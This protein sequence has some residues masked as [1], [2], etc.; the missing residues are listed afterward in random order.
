MNA[1]IFKYFKKNVML[2]NNCCYLAIFI[3]KNHLIF[4]SNSFLK[5]LFSLKLID[6]LDELE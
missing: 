2:N 6:R 5:S 4:N 1:T 3:F